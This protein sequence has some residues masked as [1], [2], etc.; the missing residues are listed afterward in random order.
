MGR[1]RLAFQGGVADV[2][3][4]GLAQLDV[5]FCTG[6]FG[7]GSGGWIVA[8]TGAQPQPPRNA[9]VACVSLTEGVTS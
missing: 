1:L 4:R 9:D 7:C 8:K 3:A 2:A 5:R 6:A